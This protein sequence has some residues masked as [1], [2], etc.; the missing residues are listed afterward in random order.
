MCITSER[1]ALQLE[2]G[3]QLCEARQ[4]VSELRA[5]ESVNSGVKLSAP[6]FVS[7]TSSRQLGQ[8]VDTPRS[9]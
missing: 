6:E 7:A 8:A 4:V 3:E 5:K 2:N 9:K 1:D